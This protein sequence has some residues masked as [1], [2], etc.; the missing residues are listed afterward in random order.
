[1]MMVNADISWFDECFRIYSP[2]DWN[3]M[4]ICWISNWKFKRLGLPA[5][6]IRVQFICH[7]AIVIY[8]C[9]DYIEVGPIFLIL[10]HYLLWQSSTTPMCMHYDVPSPSSNRRKLIF[11]LGCETVLNYINYTIISMEFSGF[12]NRWWVIY[13][14]IYSPNWQYIPLTYHLYIA[15]WVIICC[16]SHLLREPRN[17]TA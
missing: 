1:M 15:N 5:S 11:P 10:E 12:H 9:C 4:D 14:H 6:H 2:Q 8:G 13:T 7:A 17:P 3:L 16:R